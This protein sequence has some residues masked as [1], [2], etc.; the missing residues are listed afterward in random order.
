MKS[1]IQTPQRLGTV[2]ALCAIAVGCGKASIVK[3]IRRNEKLR[4]ALQA[5]LAA[6][7]NTETQARAELLAIW[8]SAWTASGWTFDEQQ[9]KFNGKTSV[10]ALL[11]GRYVLKLVFDWEAPADPGAFRFS[12][13]WYNFYEIQSLRLPQGGGSAGGPYVKYNTTN[14]AVFGPKEWRSLVESK[15][16]FSALGLHVISN[17]PVPNIG[18]LTP[19]HW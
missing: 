18:T 13:L 12:K 3:Q 16:D 5:A 2:L 7:T 10:A 14:Q 17:A 9:Q 4:P 15:W 1:W 11:Y 19:A 6:A 8:P